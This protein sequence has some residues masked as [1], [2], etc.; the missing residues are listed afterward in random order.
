M[1]RRAHDLTT[2]PGIRVGSFA[3][4]S[5][6]QVR[7]EGLD[8]R[9]DIYS[10]GVALYESATGNLPFQGPSALD[11]YRQITGETPLPPSAARPGLGTALDELLLQ[12]LAK[13]RERRPRDAAGLAASLRAL[14]P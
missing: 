1:G 10:L 3:Y 12:A 4:M 5:P 8:G 7:G 2:A 9:S 6:E 11:L 14:K 13:D